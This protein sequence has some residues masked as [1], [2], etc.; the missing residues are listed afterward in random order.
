[1]ALCAPEETFEVEVEVEFEVELEVA[2]E[3]EVALAVTVE[4]CPGEPGFP[5]VAPESICGEYF[6]ARRIPFTHVILTGSPITKRFALTAILAGIAQR[7]PLTRIRLLPSD[8]ISPV[9]VAVPENLT[10]IDG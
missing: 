4:T 1:M 2:V 8:R 10:W 6:T 7:S 9:I 3:V 5:E